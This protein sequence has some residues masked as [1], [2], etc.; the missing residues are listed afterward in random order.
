[1]FAPYSPHQPS[2]AIEKQL[3]PRN[4]FGRMG[5]ITPAMANK[6][7]ILLVNLGSPDST[8]VSDVR[9]YLREF[10][11]DERVIDYPFLLRWIIINCFVLPTRPHRSAE[12]YSRIWRT[13]GSPLVSSSKKLGSLLQS[14][15]NLP[16][17]LGMRYGNPSILSALKELRKNSPDLEEILLF[18]LYPHYAMASY[19]T[20]VVKTRD[21][22]AALGWKVQ[23]TV[24]PPFYNQPAYLD[25]M[26]ATLR[27][28]LQQPYDH[29]LFS[30]HGIPVRHLKKGD[31]TGIHCLQ[32]PDCCHTP[33]VVHANCYRHQSLYTTDAMARRCGLKPGTYSSSFQSRFGREI[34]CT[35]Y[36]DAELIR[37][38][39][40]GVKRLVVLCPAFVTDC[41][42]TLEEIGMAGKESFLEHGGESFTLVPCLNEDPKWIEALK[43]WSL[44]FPENWVT[45]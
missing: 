16:V 32:H 33:S 12:A 26:E 5:G 18:P 36:T 23:L 7:G 11:M 34:W 35:P 30:Y 2:T 44:H 22:L 39:K 24:L 38:A 31:C 3:A 25:A 20:V 1:M 14:Q 15:L 4:D 21:D 40:S 13:D 37:L 6:R 28:A 42:E 19:E 9:R 43:A 17:S 8:S 45:V 10:L 27:P 29:V 41:L